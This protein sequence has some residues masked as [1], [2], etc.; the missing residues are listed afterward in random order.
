MKKKIFIIILAFAFIVVAWRIHVK[1]RDK[2]AIGIIG[3]ADGP[4]A[5]FIAENTDADIEE[6]K[7]ENIVKEWTTSEISELFKRKT[8]E[9]CMLITCASTYDFAYDRVGTI[10]YTDSKEGYIHVAFMDKEGNI[11]HCGVEAQLV[12]S[13]EFTYLGNGAVT[14][15]VC[16]K[17]GTNYTQKITFSV[18]E[19]K[20]NFVSE[21][22]EDISEESISELKEKYNLMEPE[23]EK[24]ASKVD[25]GVSVDIDN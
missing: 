17:D 3:G 13:P 4:T 11:Q 19:N 25:V 24:V 16:S 8:S 12:E 9:D 21:A 1:L 5:V 15:K 18:D 10:L 22:I 20:V 2:A 7:A 14:F 6:I 23:E